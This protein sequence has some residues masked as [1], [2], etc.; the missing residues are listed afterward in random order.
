EPE[1]VARGYA[2]EE[3]IRVVGDPTP[4]EPFRPP[5]TYLSFDVENSL[6]DRHLLCLC[7]VVQRGDEEPRG[8]RLAG[9]EREILEGFV[10][11]VTTEDPD[12]ITGY[13]IGGYDLPL[14]GERAEAI[15]LPPLALGRD[16]APLSD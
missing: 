11:R 14:L 3:V 9:S 5:L 1:P 2:T 7:G 15:G 6:K 13:N 4:V 12:V 10:A 16:R 8:F